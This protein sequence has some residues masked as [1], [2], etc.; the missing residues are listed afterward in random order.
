M[1]EQVDQF[2]SAE[3]P[4]SNKVL[5]EGLDRT[6]QHLMENKNHLEEKCWY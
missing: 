2:V 5:L 4:M 1:T 6:I 3:A